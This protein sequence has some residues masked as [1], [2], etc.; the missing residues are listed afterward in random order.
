VYG[1][2]KVAFVQGYVDRQFHLDEAASVITSFVQE[3]WL[4]E[5]RSALG[6]RC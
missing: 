6:T 1:M 2:N 5:K 3:R 4:S